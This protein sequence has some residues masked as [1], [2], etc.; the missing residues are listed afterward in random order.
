MSKEK[1]QSLTKYAND[2]KSKLSSA[3]LPEKHKSRPVQYR[4]FLERE[5]TTVN[6]KIEF[7][8]AS[9]TADKK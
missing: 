4:Q 7:I 2:V 6:A 8:K 5:L 1:L 9:G 3:L